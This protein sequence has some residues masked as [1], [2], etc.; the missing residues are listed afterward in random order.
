MCAVMVNKELVFTGP[1]DYDPCFKCEGY[2]IKKCPQG[3][4]EKVMYTQEEMD[5]SIQKMK[6]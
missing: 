2:C 1:V 6:K 3:A 4:F 5:Q